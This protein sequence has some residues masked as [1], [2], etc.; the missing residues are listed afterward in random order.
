M[1]TKIIIYVSDL[2]IK[3]LQY[4]TGM[5][6]LLA[7]HAHKKQLHLK[8]PVFCS[9]LEV[10]IRR[11]EPDKTGNLP[12][13]STQPSTTFYG[14]PEHFNLLLRISAMHRAVTWVPG[15]STCWSSSCWPRPGSACSRRGP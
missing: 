9:I 2:E 15:V 11:L 12:M 14:P 10:F 3:Q 8:K 1:A 6:V 13:V 5:T 4:F 7:F